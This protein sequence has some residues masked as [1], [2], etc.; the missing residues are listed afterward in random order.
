MKIYRSAPFHF[1]VQLTVT[2]SHQ[3]KRWYKIT[4]ITRSAFWPSLFE[5]SLRANRRMLLFSCDKVNCLFCGSNVWKKREI[6][7]WDKSLE[8]ICDMPFVLS[9]VKSFLFKP[10]LGKFKFGLR[11]WLFT[12]CLQ[13]VWEHNLWYSGPEVQSLSTYGQ[14]TGRLR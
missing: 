7:Y 4:H 10:D 5:I 3:L 2:L 9:V 8:T 12:D 13:V 11:Y 14:T 1:V 6:N